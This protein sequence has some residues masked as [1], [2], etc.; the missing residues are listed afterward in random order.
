[1]KPFLKDTDKTYSLKVPIKRH[2]GIFLIA[3][4]TLIS[5]HGN[6][7]CRIFLK[8]QS[9]FIDY[10]AFCVNFFEKISINDFLKSSHPREQKHSKMEFGY[11]AL[12][13]DLTFTLSLKSN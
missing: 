2:G 8:S 13:D 6:C 10:H 11:R 12:L 1:M 4:S 9:F 7:V 5:Q 3:V